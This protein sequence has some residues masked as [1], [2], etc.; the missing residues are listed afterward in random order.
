[1]AT[2]KIWAIKDSLSRVVNYAKNPEKTL[3]SDLKQV[4]MYAE[5]SEKTTDEN[6]KTMYVT[7]VNCNSNTAYEEMNFV[8]KKFDKC[9]GNIAYHAYQ[10]FKTGEVLPELAHKIGVELAKEMWSEYQVVV[11]THF[12]T[13][14]YHNHFVVNS[15]NMFTGKKFNCNKGAYYKFREISD[16]LCRENNLIV[17]E[18]PKGKTPR[19]IYFA[20]KRGE[21]T[22][23]NLMR[24]AIDEA[25]AIC[26]TYDQFKKAMYKKGYIINDDPNRKYP[27]IHSIN[28]KK[29]TR[30][31][32]LGEEYLPQSIADKVYQNPYYV[33][34]K[35]YKLV[36]P[37][38]K[39][40]QY[41]VYRFKGNFKDMSKIT[42]IDALFLILFH[43][44]G[45]IPKREN[46]KPL[47]PEMRREV[48]KMERY[49]NET[50]LI[51]TEKLKTT[52]DVKSYIAQ[53]EKDIEDVT[54]L[55]QKHRN[56]LRNC[57][58]NN[59]IEEYKA[60][61]DECTT[62]LNKYRKNLKIANWILEDTPKIK[63]VIKIEQQMKIE[64][65]DITKTRKKE[66]YVG[67]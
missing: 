23:Y 58:E 11:A 63:E 19:S 47:S 50:R 48:R 54:N 25:V 38:K 41:T 39:Y 61:R 60:K 24:Q 40:K 22:K 26:L 64:Q 43:L 49:S 13:G 28:D 56:K 15:V 45:L 5:N 12:N 6:E 8:Q 3:F 42:G 57:K 62:I 31:Y 51:V 10:S 33:Q 44:L 27:T 18:N 20:E 16:R 14:T 59:L 21:P 55:R 1:M 9:T 7:G 67:R 52:E 29:A 37:K 36:K 34:D 4:L 35:Y 17:I 65:E 66:R 53:T 46:Y 32:Q 30:M 2:T